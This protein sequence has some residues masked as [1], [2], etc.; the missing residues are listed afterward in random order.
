MARK[1]AN[2]VNLGGGAVDASS[3]FARRKTMASLGRKILKMESAMPTLGKAGAVV[4]GVL[5]SGL[6]LHR[7]QGGD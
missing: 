7:L 1:H 5:G 4:G 2:L 3:V 6:A